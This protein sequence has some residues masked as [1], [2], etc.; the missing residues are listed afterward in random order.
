MKTG[1][2]GIPEF[3]TKIRT[4]YAAGYETENLCGLASYFWFVPWYGT[5]GMGNA[6]TL[7]EN[8]TITL[9]ETIS[10]R[11]SIDLPHQ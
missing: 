6:Q 9:K 11:D 4:W 10:T 2:L 3:G 7:I 5:Y 1:T 8:G